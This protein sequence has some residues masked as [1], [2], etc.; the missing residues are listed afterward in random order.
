VVSGEDPY[1]H[2]LRGRCS[3]RIR[4]KVSIGLRG[5][6]A[7]SHDGDAAP[8][9]AVGADRGGGLRLPPRR[10]GGPPAFDRPLEPLS[11]VEGIRLRLP[12]CGVGRQT[13]VR[14]LAGDPKRHEA[15]KDADRHGKKRRRGD[16][17]DPAAPSPW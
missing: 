17:S 2:L 5:L 15:G 13:P 12:P 16:R 11:S 4:G 3:R 7:A 6:S 8:P 1:D 14:R 9:A 10:V